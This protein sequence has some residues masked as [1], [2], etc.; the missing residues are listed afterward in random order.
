MKPMRTVV[1]KHLNDADTG[2]PVTLEQPNTAEARL[3]G[4][5]IRKL[6]R[7]AGQRLLKALKS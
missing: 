5:Q 6:G 3:K 7:E 1:F 2:K 4:M